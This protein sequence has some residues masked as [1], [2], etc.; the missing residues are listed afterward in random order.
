MSNVYATASDVH[1]CKLVHV[2]K[3]ISSSVLH[4]LIAKI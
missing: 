3:H 1:V 2:N 4:K